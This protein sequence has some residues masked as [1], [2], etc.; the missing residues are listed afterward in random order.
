MLEKAAFDMKVGKRP[1][2]PLWLAP[3]QVRVIPVSQDYLGVAEQ[4]RRGDRGR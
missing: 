2:L 4:G 1:T 3:T